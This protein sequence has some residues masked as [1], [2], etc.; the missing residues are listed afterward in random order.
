MQH[1]TMQYGTG[2][3]AATIRLKVRPEFRQILGEWIP[4]PPGEILAEAR[5]A[6]VD[7]FAGCHPLLAPQL[8]SCVELGELCAAFLEWA[9]VFTD[10]LWRDWL[11]YS[12]D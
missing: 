5:Q 3:Q 9:G 11:P 8:T 12:S 10:E 1:D 2:E 4:V 6:V 7:R